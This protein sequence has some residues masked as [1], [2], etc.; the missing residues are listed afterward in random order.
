MIDLSTTRMIC[1]RRVADID[2]ETL[3]HYEQQ[4]ALLRDENGFLLY[5]VR[6]T[7]IGPAEEKLMRVAA[8]E[9]LVWINEQPD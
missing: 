8:R 5:R 2:A 4:E 3:A 7:P 9:A 1:V 6:R